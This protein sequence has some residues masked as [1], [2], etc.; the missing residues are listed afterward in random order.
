M[1]K[2]VLILQIFV[3]F[4][5]AQHLQVSAKNLVKIAT[6]GAHSPVLDSSLTYQQKVDA[7]KDF[8]E[9]QVG[10]VLPDKPDLI[11]LPEACD[12]PW[13]LTSD[14]QYKYYEVRGNQ[15]LDFLSDIAKKNKC[16]IAFGMKRLDKDNLWRNSCIMLD[17]SGKIAGIYDKNFPTPDEMKRVVPSNEVKLIQTDFGK[18]GCAICFDLNFDEL[19]KRYAELRPDL[20]IFI[21][22][23]HGGMVQA[24]W[25]YSCRSWFVGSVGVGGVFSQIRNPFGKVVATSSNHFDYIVSTVNLDCELVHLDHNKVQLRELKKKY[26]DKV[27]IYDPG[28]FGVVMITSEDDNSSAED[29]VNEFNIEPLDHYFNRT[30]SDREKLFKEK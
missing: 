10:Q 4:F 25:A 28:E 15:I 29:M 8:L 17:R 26:G 16:Y 27:T 9:W 14:Q 1:K 5:V 20:M 13:G 19:Q 18:V 24:E 22:M 23:Y 30:R 21:G 6:I 2:N 7:M 11:V 3:L 12:R